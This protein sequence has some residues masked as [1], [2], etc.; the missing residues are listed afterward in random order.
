MRKKGAVNSRVRN[1]G[2]RLFISPTL[3]PVREAIEDGDPYFE[4][5]KYGAPSLH[6]TCS[7][8]S[9]TDERAREMKRRRPVFRTLLFVYSMEEQH[10]S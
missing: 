8:A 5:Y 1:T 2:R 9:L 7:L 4:L 6:F 10:P 3:S